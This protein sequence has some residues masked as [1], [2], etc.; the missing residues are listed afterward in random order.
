MA[1]IFSRRKEQYGRVSGGVVSKNKAGSMAARQHKQRR[2]KLRK[3]PWP[4][5]KSAY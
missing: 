1:G 4:L 2:M 5:S 3:Y